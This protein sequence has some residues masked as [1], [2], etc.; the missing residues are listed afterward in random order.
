MPLRGSVRR[1]LFAAGALTAALAL[2]GCVA[3]DEAVPMPVPTSAS[4][5]PSASA[6]PEPRDPEL[7]ENGTALANKEF[8]D[9]V[10]TRYLT[11]NPSPS[12]RGLID[13]LVAA[14]FDR[15]AMEVT[16]D[17][18]PLGRPVDT[19]EFSVRAY[20][21]CL[22]GQVGGFGYTSTILPATGGGTCLVG[23]TLPITW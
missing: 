18:T 19:I 2:V 16:S 8:F 7:L 20:D 12:S 22:I 13:N 21:D 6:A 11:A 23:K 5:S 14:G 3:D 15:S 1:V 17:K 4:P 10:N 9:F